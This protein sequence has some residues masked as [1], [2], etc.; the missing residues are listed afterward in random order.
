LSALQRYVA[1]R[2]AGPA[3]VSL[4]GRKYRLDPT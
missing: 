1:E 4:D 3:V 2:D